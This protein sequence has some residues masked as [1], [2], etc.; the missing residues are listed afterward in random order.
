ME[1]AL[2]I[3]EAEFG[4][5][6]PEVVTLV[7]LLAQARQAEKRFAEAELLYQRALTIEEKKLDPNQRELAIRLAQLATLYSAQNRYTEAEALLQRAKIIAEEVFNPNDA[8][9]GQI[10]NNY[11]AVLKALGQ[12]NPAEVEKKQQ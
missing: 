5:D 1:H 7:V 4:T 10:Q 12:T 2:E 11:K 3:K 6:H 9:F 8:T